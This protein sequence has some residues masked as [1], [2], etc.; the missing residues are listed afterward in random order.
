[1]DDKSFEKKIDS[2]IRKPT[3]NIENIKWFIYI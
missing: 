3:T 1:M 2:K